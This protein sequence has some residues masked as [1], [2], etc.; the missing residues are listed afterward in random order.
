MLRCSTLRAAVKT[1]PGLVEARLTLASVLSA[2]G[3]E[4][5]R[6]NRRRGGA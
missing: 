4:R 2:A 1:K 5:R 6:P 3:E